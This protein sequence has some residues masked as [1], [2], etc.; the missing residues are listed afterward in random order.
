MVKKKKNNFWFI[1]FFSKFKKNEF[2]I[3]KYSKYYYDIVL[4]KKIRLNII[5]TK[6][7]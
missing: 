4:K 5:L 7:L 6:L 1:F 2:N 3:K